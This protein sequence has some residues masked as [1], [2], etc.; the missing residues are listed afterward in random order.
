MALPVLKLN[1]APPPTLWRQ[2]HVFI[3]WAVLVAGALSLGGALVATVLAYRQASIAGQR[4]VD[5]TARRQSAAKKQTDIQLQ[6]E[7]IDVEK[8]LPRWRLAERILAERSLPW[9]RLAVEL[10]R[11]L[12]QDVRIKNIQ[13]TRNSR[14]EVELKIKGEARNRLAEDAFFESLH[15]STFFT[16]VIL[17]RESETQGGVLEFECVLPASSTPPPYEPLPK[18]GPARAS[19]NTAAPPPPVPQKPVPQRMAPAAPRPPVN[20][21]PPL[22]TRPAPIMQP[23]PGTPPSSPTYRPNMPPIRRQFPSSAPPQQE[24][25]R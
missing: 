8:E 4:V 24:E 16:Q 13:R 25:R 3:A 6:L 2:Y 5:L 1:L 19:T 11:C 14:Q 20:A 9:S 21:P 7:A 15:K 22:V 12:V 23:H 10:E 17:E 18:F